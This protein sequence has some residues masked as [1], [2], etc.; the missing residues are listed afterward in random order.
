M[1]ASSRTKAQ[2]TT[3]RKLRRVREKGQSGPMHTQG[4]P[5]LVTRKQ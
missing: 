3:S 5:L 2:P 1:G 4:S